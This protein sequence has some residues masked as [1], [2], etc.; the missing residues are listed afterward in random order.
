MIVHLSAARDLLATQSVVV[1]CANAT[2]QLDTSD[3]DRD[4]VLL[5]LTSPVSSQELPENFT[6]ARLPAEDLGSEVDAEALVLHQVV[7]GLVSHCS[8]LDVKTMP[9]TQLDH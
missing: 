4:L 9:L 3:V 7:A 6:F 8:R 2:R 5:I 1:V